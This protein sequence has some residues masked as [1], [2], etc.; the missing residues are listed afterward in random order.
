MNIF[1]KKYLQ[2]KNKIILHYN[3]KLILYHINY[4]GKLTKRNYNNEM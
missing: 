1:I 3:T 2:F 4:I